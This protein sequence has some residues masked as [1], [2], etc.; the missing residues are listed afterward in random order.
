MQYP[1]DERNQIYNHSNV[2]I[3]GLLDWIYFF[4]PHARMMK[5]LESILLPSILSIAPIVQGWVKKG[6]WLTGRIT[7]DRVAIDIS[8]I[9]A[10]DI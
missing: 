7:K 4:T 5:P 6:V 9:S 2:C 1:S 10:A 8:F 3:S